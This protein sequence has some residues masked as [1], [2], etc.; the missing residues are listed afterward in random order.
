[1]NSGDARQS[2][3]GAAA[4]TSLRNSPVRA[5][6]RPPRILPFCCSHLLSQTALVLPVPNC[7]SI[8]IDGKPLLTREYSHGTGTSDA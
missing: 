6:F 5:C 2:A 4:L 3:S 8:G 7:C 1:M